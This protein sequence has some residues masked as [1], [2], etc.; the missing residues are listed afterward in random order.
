METNTKI[1]SRNR[2]NKQKICR[3]VSTERRC[4][5]SGYWR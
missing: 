4:S 2:G 1:Q 5:L 3:C